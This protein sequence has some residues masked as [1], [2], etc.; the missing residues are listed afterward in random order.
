MAVFRAAA[1]RTDNDL[2]ALGV[3]RDV[4]GV[5]HNDL[6]LQNF[7]FYRKGIFSRETVSVIDFDL[8]GW[9]H[10][11]FDLAWLLSLLKFSYGDYAAS[12]QAALLEGYQRKRPMSRDYW[13]Y[14]GTFASM[15]T[16]DMVNRVLGWENPSKNPWG[17]RLLL[18]AIEELKSYVEAK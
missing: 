2:R 8:C 4:F 1:V 18:E 13:S 3:G 14:L 10:Y 5:I 6:L 11:H 17:W 16:V 15:R 9:G 12:L 7:M